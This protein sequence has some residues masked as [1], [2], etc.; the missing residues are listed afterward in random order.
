MCPLQVFIRFEKLVVCLW[1]DYSS[2][3]QWIT[4]NLLHTLLI[5]PI[6][7]IQIPDE[8][9]VYAYVQAWTH[10]QLIL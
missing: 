9:L 2:L 8:L 1:C 6:N 4:R 7:Q 10:S 5:L 3:L